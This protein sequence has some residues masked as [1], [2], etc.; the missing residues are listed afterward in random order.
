MPVG[1]LS[2]TVSGCELIEGGRRAAAAECIWLR[3]LAAFD[4]AGECELDGHMTT[5][6]WL[7]DRC[8]LA[9]PTAKEKLRV[10]RELRRRPRLQEPF[11]AGDLSYSKVRALTRVADADDDTETAL[12][13]AA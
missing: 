9:R 8:G 1:A 7:I 11:A 5:V 12:L 4:A 3:Q 13:A 6:S 10:A 2:A